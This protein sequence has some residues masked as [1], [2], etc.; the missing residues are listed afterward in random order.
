MLT[1]PEFAAIKT[2]QQAMWATGDYAIVGN[3]L[4]L[5]AELL[6]EEMDLHSGWKVLDVAAGN[7]NASLAA[8][9]RGCR[10]ISTDYVPAMLEGGRKRAAAEGLKIEFQEADAEDLPFKDESFDAVISCVGVQYTPHQERA[11]AELLRVCKKGGRIG[12][13]NW[14]PAGFVGQVFKIVGKYAP[15]AAGVRPSYGWGTEFRLHELF[16]AA[17]KIETNRR[18]FVFRSHST[19]RWLDVLTMYYGPMVRA[20]GSLE[21]TERVAVWAELVELANASN[22]AKDGTMVVPS[23]YLEA[24]ITK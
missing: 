9:R 6:C 2:R 24:V 23:E 22:Q 3:A 16:R 5:M 13:A 15:L 7:G 19:E 10:V 8:A 18:D 11:A 12:L 14:T 17:A 1:L 21:E 4:S 20:M